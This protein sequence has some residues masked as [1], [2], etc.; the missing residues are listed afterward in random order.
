MLFQKSPQ[1]ADVTSV[2]AA[3]TISWRSWDF[4]VQINYLY[5]SDAENNPMRMFCSSG[6]KCLIYASVILVVLIHRFHLSQFPDLMD[7]VSV[8]IP[9]SK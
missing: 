7:L 2:T 6:E 5:C 3:L 1:K 9:A 8:V 4:I